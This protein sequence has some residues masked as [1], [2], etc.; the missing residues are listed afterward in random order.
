ML[1]YL[2][3]FPDE[4]AA[5]SALPDRL[6]DGEWDQSCVIAGQRVVLARAVWDH[7]NPEAPVEVSP[8]KVAPGWHVTV[9]ASKAP[10]AYAKH[11]CVPP[12]GAVVEPAPAGIPVAGG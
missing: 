7:R 9:I 10:A 3:K 1:A 12:A 8:E 6:I 5:K 11:K 4:A 2:M